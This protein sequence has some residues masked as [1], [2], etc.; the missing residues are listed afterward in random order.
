MKQVCLCVLFLVGFRFSS[1]ATWSIIVADPKT[2]MIG[3]AGAS[4][5]HSVYG[6]GIIAPGQGAIVVQAMSNA[7]ARLKGFEMIRE[8][9]K[10]AAIL[11]Q[12]M[13]PQYSPQVQQYAI[14]CL[15]EVEKPLVF[16]GAETNAYGGAMTGYGVSAQGNTL[17]DSNEVKVIYEAAVK[18]QKDG[19]PL[20]EV[21]MLALEAGARMGGDK[22]CG[23]RKASSAFLI[24][25]KPTDVAEYWLKLVVY[26][27]DDQTPAVD[28]LRKKYEEWKMKPNAGVLNNAGN[29]DN[30]SVP[31]FV[32]VE[33]V[34]PKE[35]IECL[36]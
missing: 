29:S 34:L 21:L 15:N 16:T 7:L 10:P 24:V 26:G 11:K 22:R 5:T 32:H 14:L 13:S 1:F 12:L 33:F 20:Q 9:A 18:G 28:A 2:K 23:E 3:I 35:D 19:L 30:G 36:F 25:C 4:C 31:E 8:G 27:D 17:A 6:I